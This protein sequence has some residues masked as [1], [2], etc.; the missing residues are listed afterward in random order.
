MRTESLDN[1]LGR[2]GCVTRWR[3]RRFGVAPPMAAIRVGVELG[4]FTRTVGSLWAAVVG[5][6]SLRTAVRACCRKTPR[7]ASTEYAATTRV[8]SINNC[9]LPYI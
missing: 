6:S 4:A 2:G 7:L 3:G 9:F 8:G 5:P 1:G